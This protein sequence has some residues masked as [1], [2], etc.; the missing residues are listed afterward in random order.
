MNNCCK[1]MVLTLHCTAVS[2]CEQVAR[3]PGK[4]LPETDQILPSQHKMRVIRTE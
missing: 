4:I 1:T 2:S 3:K